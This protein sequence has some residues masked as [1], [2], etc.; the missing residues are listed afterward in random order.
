MNAFRHRKNW[1]MLLLILSVFGS[2]GGHL[3][4]LQSVAWASMLWNNVQ[5]DRPLAAVQKTFDGHHPCG[6][7]HEIAADQAERSSIPA[8][9]VERRYDPCDLPQI[10][11][12]VREW[13]VGEVRWPSRYS[14]LASVTSLPATPPPRRASSLLS[15]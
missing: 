2:A 8:Q 15:A 9:E 12:A 3:M 10:A 6:R 14:A 4:A 13:V 1:G 5:H 11:N 7:C